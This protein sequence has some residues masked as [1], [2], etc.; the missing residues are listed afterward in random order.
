MF[1]FITLVIAT[2]AIALTT[3]STAVEAKAMVED[4]GRRRVLEERELGNTPV[5]KGRCCNNSTSFEWAL[6]GESVFGAACYWKWLNPG[7]CVGGVSVA[8]P[9]CEG[10]T[11]GGGFYFVKGMKTGACVTPGQDSPP[12]DTRRWTPNKKQCK[13]QSPKDRGCGMI[14]PTPPGYPYGFRRRMLL[15]AVE[16]EEECEI[17]DSDSEE[18]DPEE[19]E[20]EVPTIVPEPVEVGTTNNSATEAITIDLEQGAGTE[21]PP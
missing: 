19:P 13:A 9:D 21:T 4:S 3:M 1:R 12:Y 2:L 10:M 16:L 6:I 14:N 5:H 11:C 15:R 18:S 8:G 17:I 20:T 7:E